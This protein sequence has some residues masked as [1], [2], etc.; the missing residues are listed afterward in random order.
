MKKINTKNFKKTLSKFTTGV[1]VICVRKNQDI[2]GKTVNS[3]NSLSLN[4]P[5]VLFSLGNY[6]SSIKIYLKSKFLT[7]NI[8][9]KKQV[10]ISNHFA[11]KEPKPIKIDFL[12]GK[13][14]TSSISDCVANLECKV[15]DK[16]KKGDHIIFICKVLNVRHDD[17]LKPLSYYNS[18]YC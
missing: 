4:P 12:P 10:K 1:T 8:L 18:K 15:I 6:S 13:N 11:K 7:I 9:S 16:I 17:K 5:L 2:Y 3:F 14:N